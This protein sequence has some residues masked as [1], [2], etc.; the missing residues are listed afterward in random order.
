MKEKKYKWHKLADDIHEINF[1]SN[2][3]TE[4]E[5]VGKTICIALK[6]D[7]LHACTH[8]C[9]HAGGN[10]VDGY[11]D[12][13]GN[14]V[15]PLHPY[16]FNLNNGRNISGEGYHLKTFPIEIRKEGVFVGFE[17]NILLNWLK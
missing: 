6:N 8:K 2:G 4:L 12:A 11:L 1:S 3:M 5:V 13:L 16:K 7:I 9:P 14:I 10:L 17:E 15:C